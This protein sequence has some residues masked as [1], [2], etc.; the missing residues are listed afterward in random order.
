MVDDII[1]AHQE[2]E[3]QQP[4]KN[5]ARNTVLAACVS[6][7][8]V[9]DRDGAK[10]LLARAAVLLPRLRLVWADQGYTGE[11][12]VSWARRIAGVRIG[13]V[14]RADS[15][16]R[17]AWA[18]KDRPPPSVP[19][20]AVVPRRWVVERTFAWLGGYRR[21]AKDYEYLAAN[22]ENVSC[23]VMSLILAHRMA[24]AP[25]CPFSDTF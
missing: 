21:T 19:R 24:R 9:G 6:P 15:G 12:L 18:P 14:R 22:S 5:P 25:S 4:L 8:S 13:I 1:A 17:R 16:S 20:F 10:V 2:H 23:L 7:A 11:R 3:P